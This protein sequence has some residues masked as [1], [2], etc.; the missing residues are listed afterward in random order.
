METAVAV[1]VHWWIIESP[2]AKDGE[3]HGQCRHCGAERTF[4]AETP[5]WRDE[6]TERHLVEDDP[7]LVC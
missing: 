2:P 4:L 3:L 1:C 6:W 7:C 5:T